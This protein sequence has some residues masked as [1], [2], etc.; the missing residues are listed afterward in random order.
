M[1]RPIYRFR[2]FAADFHLAEVRKYLQNRQPDTE[3]AEDKEG[4]FVRPR[5]TQTLIDKLFVRAGV[6]QP[7][8]PVP[9][10]RGRGRPKKGGQ[11][12]P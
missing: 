8:P 3:I 9:V 6:Q 5:Q 4:Q 2:G 11:S 7:P 12:A 1:G 10:K